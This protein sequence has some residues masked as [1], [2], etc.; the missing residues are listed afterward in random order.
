MTEITLEPNVKDDD[1]DADDDGKERKRK[2]R[3]SSSSSSSRKRKSS[4]TPKADTDLRGRLAECFERIALA[5]ENRGDDE[6]AQIVRD[7]GPVMAQGLVSLT[8]PFRVL[9]V[10]VLAL[11]S[12][13]EPVLAFGRLARA[14]AERWAVRRAQRAAAT[15]PPVE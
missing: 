3:S 11:V 8:R 12:V 6:L 13:V 15:E 2:R 7:D 14:V 10:F 9:R 1:S 5:L 4:S